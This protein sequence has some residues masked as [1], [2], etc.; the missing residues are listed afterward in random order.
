MASSDCNLLD[1]QAKEELHRILCDNVD[2]DDDESG[3]N[4]ESDYGERGVDCSH[5]IDD[6]E[7][8]DDTDFINDI[9]GANEVHGTDDID[10]GTTVN[11]WSSIS[12]D[13]GPYWESS[14]CTPYY[15]PTS[16]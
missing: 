4:W 12:E 8:T 6:I 14:K 3:D 15:E 13:I 2:V 1:V 10:N 16:E 11:D 5:D 9:D 7:D